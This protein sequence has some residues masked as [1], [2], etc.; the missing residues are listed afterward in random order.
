MRFA[1]CI[2]KDTQ[3]TG[4]R[5]KPLDRRDRVAISLCREH[6]T[7][8]HRLAVEKDRAGATDTMLAARVAADKRKILTK[9]I[10]QRFPR[11]DIHLPD[12]SVDRERNLHCAPP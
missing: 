10:Q 2:L 7:R 6:Q 5:S 11:L 12:A 9:R 8:A 4:S 1:E 3:F